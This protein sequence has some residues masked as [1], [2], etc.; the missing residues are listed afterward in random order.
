M[1]EIKVTDY[2]GNSWYYQV[3][4]ESMFDRLEAAYLNGQ[5]T[6]MIDTDELKA[7]QERLAKLEHR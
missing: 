2:Y 5:K 7:F 3:M 1:T 6:M 4:T